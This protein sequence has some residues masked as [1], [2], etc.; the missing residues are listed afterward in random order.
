MIKK[1][2]KN[3]FII[4]IV[5]LKRLILIFMKMKMNS[6]KFAKMKTVFFMINFLKKKQVFLFWK[7]MDF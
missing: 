7:K 6:I 4:L 5:N 3:S 2:I 1:L